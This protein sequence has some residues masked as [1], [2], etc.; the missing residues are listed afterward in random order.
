MINVYDEL[1]RDMNELKNNIGRKIY[2]NDVEAILAWREIMR[3]TRERTLE[4]IE[5]RASQLAEAAQKIRDRIT[6]EHA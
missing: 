4:D 1:E 2:P 3:S 6:R 5:E